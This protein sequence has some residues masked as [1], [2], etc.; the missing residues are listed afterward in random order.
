MIV[1][2]ACSSNSGQNTH[3]AR[4]GIDVQ[5]AEIS[6][7]PKS[8]SDQIALTKQDLAQRQGKDVN[9][10][11]LV[12]ARQVTWRSGALGCPGQVFTSDVM[13]GCNGA[14]TLNTAGGMEAACSPG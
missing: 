9:S 8:L 3:D 2:S 7:A 1:L 14:Y 10:I 4:S 12:A 5:Q 11:I 6:A 13:V